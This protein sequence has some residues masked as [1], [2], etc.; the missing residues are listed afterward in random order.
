MAIQQVLAFIAANGSSR[1]ENPKDYEPIEY[2]DET[3]AMVT[4][5]RH[6][7]KTIMRAG[8]R[9]KNGDDWD[10][11]VTAPAWRTE[12]CEGF[13]STE[14]AR[15]LRDLKLLRHDDGRLT[16]QMR[17]PG[18]GSVKVYHLRGAI[19]ADDTPDGA[20]DG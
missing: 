10:Y 9:E 14:I 17:F 3:G 12:L 1:F 5:D 20:A 15:A 19:L 8:W 2:R 11:F 4:R 13:N 7:P 18:H 6:P 16:R